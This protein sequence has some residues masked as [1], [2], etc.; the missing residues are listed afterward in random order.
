[1]ALTWENVSDRSFIH[2][3]CGQMGDPWVIYG[4]G[5]CL[6]QPHQVRTTACRH[7]TNRNLYLYHCQYSDT[8]SELPLLANETI[9]HDGV[10]RPFNAP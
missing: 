3:Q 1:M 8:G 6:T 9:Y 10:E 2:V 4:P 5:H 7:V